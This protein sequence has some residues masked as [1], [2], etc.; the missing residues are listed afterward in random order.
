MRIVLFIFFLLLVGAS[1]ALY[2]LVPTE[3]WL[4]RYR[5]TQIMSEKRELEFLLEAS[6]RLGKFWRE[7]DAEGL[8]KTNKLN[9]P[10]ALGTAFDVGNDYLKCNPRFILC[11]M[12]EKGLTIELDGEDRDIFLQKADY[13]LV[14]PSNAH[15]S[16][17]S[18]A[19]YLFELKSSRGSKTLPL[20]LED[21]CREVFLP[22]RIYKYKDF[23]WDNYNANIF[24]DQYPVTFLEISDWL[25][26]SSDK[27]GQNI[28][29]PSTQ[30]SLTQFAYGLTLDE[31]KSYCA[32]KGKQLMSSEIFDAAS[33]Y[34]ADLNN[35]TEEV[36]TNAPYPW[37]RKKKITED[38]ALCSKIYSEECLKKKSFA[39]F[40]NEATTWSG[41]FWA[42][43]GPLEALYN[44]V[45]SSLN[46]KASSF[47]FPFTSSWQQLA[48]RAHWEG[49][50]THERDFDWG[51][52]NERPTVNDNLKIGFRCMRAV[53]LDERP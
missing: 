7:G 32:F 46:M 40:S 12:E 4:P 13:H 25:R 34:P 6:K 8:W 17:L 29:L 47:Y 39:S 38:E 53:Y 52:N 48:E 23:V 33:V 19:S 37:T 50:E 10:K 24:I 31:M 14:T 26:F 36:V 44:P 3:K 18:R 30:K 27:V 1:L 15:I 41:M 43:G 9:C 49:G 28:K 35:P 45:D 20:L 11:L 16:H 21:D 51:K 5:T 42:L 22:E 2:I